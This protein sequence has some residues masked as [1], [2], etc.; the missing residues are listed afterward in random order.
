MR[1]VFSWKFSPIPVDVGQEK[2]VR[3]SELAVEWGVRNLSRTILPATLNGLENLVA[4]SDKYFMTAKNRISRT[5][6]KIS[7]M[8]L[9]RAND[10]N[11]VKKPRRE[12]NLIETVIHGWN[13]ERR[14]RFSF[15][16]K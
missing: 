6:K 14:S 9:F 13:N 15:S 5:K 11:R 7:K 8:K 12:F 3:A 1:P 4:L 16:T 10:S 2:N